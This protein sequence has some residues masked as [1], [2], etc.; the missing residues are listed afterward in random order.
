MEECRRGFNTVPFED[1]S[2]FGDKDS[3]KGGK[4]ILITAYAAKNPSFWGANTVLWDIR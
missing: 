4:T 1:F 3:S 2:L